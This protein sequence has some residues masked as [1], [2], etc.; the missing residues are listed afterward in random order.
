MQCLF[1]KIKILAGL[2]FIILTFPLFASDTTIA[3][4]ST[5]NIKPWGYINA[6]GH[7][8][9]L[10]V[11]LALALENETGISINNHLHP[12]PRVIHEIKNGTTDFAV[13]FNSPQAREIGISV[14][15]VV[16]TKIL[17]I[18]LKN[19]AAVSS[20][21]DVKGKHIGYLRGSKY[22]AV[23]DNNN[24]FTKVPLD[25]MQQGIKMLLK[26]R[27]HGVVGAERT[28]YYRLN[29]LGILAKEVQP[30]LT[31]SQAS[32]DLYFS[33]ASKNKHLIEPFKAAL[34]KLQLK[35][36]LNGFLQ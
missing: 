2:L 28:F 31:I 4:F 8:D 23:F 22:G 26:K 16:D 30:L 18:G 3:N 33:K 25:S 36:R 7:K 19:S 21:K 11:K 14:G 15:W 6:E 29:Q 1:T 34:K 12:Y 17:L 32:G 20:L 24:S 5:S 9:G 10:L 27:I 13:M 35:G